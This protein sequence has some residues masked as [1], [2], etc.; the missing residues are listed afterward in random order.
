[1]LDIANRRLNSKWNI[2]YCQTDASCFKSVNEKRV[3]TTR[4][5]SL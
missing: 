4:G 3:N 1:M 5:G 2:Q